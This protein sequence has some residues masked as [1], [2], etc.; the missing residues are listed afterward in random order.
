MFKSEKREKVKN[1]NR[2]MVVTGRS[3]FNII[4]FISRKYLTKKKI[5]KN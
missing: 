5:I 2:K 4:N 3:V 1:N